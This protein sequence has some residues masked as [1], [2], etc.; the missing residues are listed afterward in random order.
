MK[1]NLGI[2]ITIGMILAISACSYSIYGN[3]ESHSII[4]L[5]KINKEGWV[6]QMLTRHGTLHTYY[7]GTW[8]NNSSIQTFFKPL[9]LQQLYNDTEEQA[10]IYRESAP[11]MTVD[12]NRHHAGASKA[13]AGIPGLGGGLGSSGPQED[14]PLTNLNFPSYGGLKLPPHTIFNVYTINKDKAYILCPTC[15]ICRIVDGCDPGFGNLNSNALLEWR[16][17]ESS[18]PI[19]NIGNNSIIFQCYTV[20]DTESEC[21][22]VCENNNNNKCISTIV[23]GTKFQCVSNAPS[24][25]SECENDTCSDGEQCR[26]LAEKN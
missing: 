12:I 3:K 19:S 21:N 10:K 7:K 23:G 24:S 13:L 16:A 9:T 26:V 15:D 6:V 17:S 20:F 18:I 5:D 2:S 22:E 1:K 4:D 25:T 8:K 14:F 11:R